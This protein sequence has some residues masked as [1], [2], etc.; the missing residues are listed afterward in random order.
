MLKQVLKY[1][2]GT[3]HMKLC[4]LV[5]NLQTVTWWLDSSYSVHWDSRINTVM[6]ALICQAAG[7]RSLIQ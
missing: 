3:M 6:V 1:L 7:A 5:D 2:Y 4:L